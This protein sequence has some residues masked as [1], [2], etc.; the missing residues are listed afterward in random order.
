MAHW[1]LHLLVLLGILSTAVVFGTDMFF[2]TIGRAAL[3]QA[4]P[5]AATEVMGFLHFYADARM[6]I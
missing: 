5:A 6:P 2:L 3:R 4:S 1:L